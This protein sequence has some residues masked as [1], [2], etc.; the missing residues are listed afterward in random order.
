MDTTR[1]YWHEMF[2][3]ALVRSIASDPESLPN[4]KQPG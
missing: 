2:A 1:S 4:G 3:A